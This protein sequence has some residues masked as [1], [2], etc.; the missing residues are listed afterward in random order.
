MTSCWASKCSCSMSSFYMRLGTK[1]SQLAYH[2]TSSLV[3][4]VFVS[5]L[6][7]SPL[8]SCNRI[9]F[10]CKPYVL[11]L[12][13]GMDK[14]PCF[15]LLKQWHICSP[16][17]HRCILIGHQASSFHLGRKWELCSLPLIFDLAQELS[18]T[19]LKH[20]E[21]HYD[22]VIDFT[23]CHPLVELFLTYPHGLVISKFFY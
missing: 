16:F 23:L 6:L 9:D 10:M 13:C 19:T 11:Q 4:I 12:I 17:D 15:I 21:C 8:K 14:F 5:Y 20:Y 18:E 2:W 7:S 3:M 1:F 22:D